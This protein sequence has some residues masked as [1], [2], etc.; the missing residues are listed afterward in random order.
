MVFFDIASNS[1]KRPFPI[2]QS[3]PQYRQPSVICTPLLITLRCLFLALVIGVF[4]VFIGDLTDK[5][6]NGRHAF[7]LRSL[8]E[9][10]CNAG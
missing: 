5:T 1:S 8:A 3:E 2:S 7:D 9:R 10:R 4:S 6:C